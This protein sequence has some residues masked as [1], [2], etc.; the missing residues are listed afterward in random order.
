MNDMR[1]V[2]VPKSDQINADD[3]LTG[4][5]TITVAKVE[6]RPGTEQ[7]VSVR[8]EN[9][10][11][12]PYK[13]CKSMARVMVHCWGADANNYIGRSMT[14][15]CD[16][17]VMWAGMA[18]GGIRISHMTDIKGTQVMALTATKGNKKPFTVQPLKLVD[19]PASTVQ[20]GNWDDTPDLEKKYPTLFVVRD[21]AAWL[22]NLGTVLASAQTPDDVVEVEGLSPVSD[23]MLKAPPAVQA[24]IKTMLSG[25][26]TRVSAEAWEEPTDGQGQA[27]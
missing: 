17:K 9:D 24:Q 7:P 5:M 21:K 15:Y 2:I 18:V 8:F 16:P 19:T 12:K 20:G 26:M 27:A 14:L 13:P 10:N 22:A 3:L 4:P 25:A 23:A 11:G 6:I 1:A